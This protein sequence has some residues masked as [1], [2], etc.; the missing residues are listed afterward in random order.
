MLLTLVEIRNRMRNCN[1]SAHTT[2]D[3]VGGDTVALGWEWVGD[4]GEQ[5]KHRIEVEV[6]HISVSCRSFER[7]MH[8]A[9]RFMKY[10]VGYGL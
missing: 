8:K 4:D 6:H 2:I 1:P 7:Q 3:F 5:H 9:K 10:T